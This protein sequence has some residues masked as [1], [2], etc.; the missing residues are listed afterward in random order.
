M[1]LIDSDIKKD[2]KVKVFLVDDQAIVGEKVK[3]MLQDESDIEFY[4]CSEPTEAVKKAAEFEPTVILQDLVMPDVDGLTLVRFYRNHPNLKEVPVI[5]LSSKEEAE[6]KAESFETGANDYLVKL[7]DSVELIARIKYHSQ[8]Y[9]ALLQRNEAY[10]ALEASQKSLKR[11]LQKAA[12]Y[13]KSLLPEPINT[14]H[15]KALWRFIPS[16]QLGG[17]NF[18]YHKIDDDHYAIYLLDVCGH[19]VG[20]ALM[21]V[22]AHN[23]L[24]RETLPQTDFRNPASVARGLNSSFQMSDHNDYYFTLWYGVYN[25]HTRML[26]FISAGHPPALKEYKGEVTKLEN[27]NFIIGGLPEFNFTATSV[28]ME[29]SCNLYIFS[30]GAYEIQLGNDKMWELDDMKDYLMP[31]ITE[32]GAE[33][34][35]L[36]KHACELQNT[37]VLDDDYSIM[38][39]IFK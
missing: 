39:L 7:P 21:S 23:V 4:F 26:S 34:D 6:T 12:D 22:S 33:M 32:D 10:R 3:R 35:E 36:Y 1:N 9:I 28:K 16:T 37:E 18:G 17:D 2:F 19:G 14:N 30:D 8:G 24:R 29:E 11:E 5:V 31:R 25:I 27:D 13:V 15:I 38:Q 20:S